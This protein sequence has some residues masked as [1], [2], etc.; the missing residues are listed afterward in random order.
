MGKQRHPEEFKAEAAKQ[1]TTPT[2]AC[3]WVERT[4]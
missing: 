2:V 4:K 1:I 3:S